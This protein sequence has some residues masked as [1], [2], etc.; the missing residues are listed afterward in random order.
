MKTKYLTAI[1]LLISIIF[2][3]NVYPAPYDYTL[4]KK[5]EEIKLSAG[6][7]TLTF[8]CYYARQKTREIFVK[9]TIH[10]MIEDQLYKKWKVELPK[11]KEDKLIEYWA[12]S[13]PS[14]DFSK[15]HQQVAE[16][17]ISF[18]KHISEGL[19][20]LNKQG[21]TPQE[22]YDTYISKKYPQLSANKWFKY[23]NLY[24]NPEDIKWMKNYVKATPQKQR[25]LIFYDQAVK[26]IKYSIMMSKIYS[27]YLSTHS[28]PNNQ[29]WQEYQKKIIEADIKSLKVQIPEK[30][31]DLLPL[32]TDYNKSFGKCSLR[33]LQK[34]RK[35]IE[36]Y[37][38]ILND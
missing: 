32:V 19:E 36:T 28:N 3:T 6:D 35:E 37:L 20:L 22:V 25:I 5:P 11:D 29:T 14:K 31:K 13:Q 26:N 2:S 10:S 21:L 27:K 34:H 30:Y 8:Q 1:I 17:H 12:K 33:F 15:F 9:F 38:K 24:N 23:Y 16:A 4:K 7:E 18:C